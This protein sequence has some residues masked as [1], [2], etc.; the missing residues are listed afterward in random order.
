LT[1]PSKQKHFFKPSILIGLF[2]LLAFI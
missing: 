2:C 1:L